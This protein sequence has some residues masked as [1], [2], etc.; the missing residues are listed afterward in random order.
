[1]SDNF[2]SGFAGLIGAPNVGKST[3]LNHMLGEK[4]SITSSKPQTTRNRILGVVHREKA[5]IVVLDTP[6][7][8]DADSPL[9]R[10]MVDVAM[11]C[12][13]DVDLLMFVIDASRPDPRSEELALKGL[14]KQ[15]RPVV[16]VINKIDLV[17]KAQLLPI[18]AKWQNVY[19]FSSM[20]PVSAKHGTQVGELLHVLEEL[21]PP[22]PPFFPED[23]LTDMPERFVAAEMIREKVFRLTSQEIPYSVAVTID[24][25]EEQAEPPMVKISAVIHV[26]RDSQKGIVI[27]KAGAMLKKIG[28]SARM[29]I[30]RMVGVKV[31]LKLFVRVEKNW[32]SDTKAMRRLGYE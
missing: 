25:F 22:G 12:M 21:L 7:I 19:N 4:V 2:R 23:S 27:G 1:M 18:L 15:K 16:L 5:Q 11:T 10:H 30:E 26:E 28:T 3:L 13:G 24:S 20:V 29:E 14:A 6:G 31:F 9:N 32:S 17:E 8:H